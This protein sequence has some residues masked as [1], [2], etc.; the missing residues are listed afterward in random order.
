MTEKNYTIDDLLNALKNP[1]SVNEEDKH[2]VKG[3]IN[4]A[5][6]WSKIGR[7]AAD[8]LGIEESELDSFLTEW[9][10]DNEYSNLG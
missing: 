7:R 5:E 2:K 6:T 4:N 10:A 3:L 8:E 9:C 1:N